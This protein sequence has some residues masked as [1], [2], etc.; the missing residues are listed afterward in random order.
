MSTLDCLEANL[1]AAIAEQQ[2]RHAAENGRDI[3]RE[4]CVEA[5][6]VAI[7]AHWGNFCSHS[8][9]Q[10]RRLGYCNC[11][12]DGEA[13]LDAALASGYVIINRP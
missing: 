10:C 1:D 6:A 7:K 11:W 3:E 2:A 9:P 13:A 4:R 8:V 12:G 5:M